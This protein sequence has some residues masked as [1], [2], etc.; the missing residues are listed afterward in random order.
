MRARS[1]SSSA[2]I[3]TPPGVGGKDAAKTLARHCRDRRLLHY[4]AAKAM[5]GK[6]RFD[7]G[8]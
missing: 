7:V 5:G 8:Q 2:Y 1:E 3:A 4:P 6:G